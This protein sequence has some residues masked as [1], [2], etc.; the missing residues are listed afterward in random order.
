MSL[1]T[2]A[3]DSIVMGLEDYMS[4]DKKRLISCT[5]NLFA[6]ILLLFKHKLSLLSPKSSEESLIKQRVLPKID[7][8]GNV[9]WVGDGRKTVDVQQIKERLAS[10]KIS[11]HWDRVEEINKF[12]NDI[13]HYYSRLSKDAMR[14][15]IANS[16]II[17]R[18][19]LFDHL[20]QDP[21]VFLGDDAWNILLSVAEVYER[22]KEDCIRVIDGINWGSFSLY[23]ALIDYKCECC[24]SGL[25]TISNPQCVREETTFCCRSCGITWEFE[26]IAELAVVEYFSFQNYTSYVDGGEPGT[27]TC[28]ECCRNTY[29]LHEQ[30]CAVCEASF[31][32]N[33]QRCGMDIPPEEIDGS[34]FC[35][36]CSHMISKED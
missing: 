8:L 22:E 20:N 29:I 25:I 7:S 5:R 11:V 13:E 30:Y 32:H 31:D 18:D 21:K 2:N 9:I 10:L 35:G 12:R 33:C 36:W 19:F 27:I 26:K 16:F 4:S 34:G 28:P 6:G 23:D 24:G 17:I 1:L 14:S 15:V 3:R